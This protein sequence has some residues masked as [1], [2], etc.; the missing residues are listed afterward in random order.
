M[1]PWGV[2]L[3]LFGYYSKFLFC[4]F[5]CQINQKMTLGW[6]CSQNKVEI[7][8]GMLKKYMM[9]ALHIQAWVSS[10]SFSKVRG[11][12]HATCGIFLR[13]LPNFIFDSHTGPFLVLKNKTSWTKEGPIQ[14][15]VCSSMIGT[16]FYSYINSNNLLYEFAKRHIFQLY[17][18]NFNVLYPI[19]FVPYPMLSCSALN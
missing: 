3:Y 8:W 13:F 16:C 4:L 7:L 10:W 1:P 12:I 9:W 18:N 17:L 14:D 6:Y 15:V 19:L 5:S 11:S 2:C